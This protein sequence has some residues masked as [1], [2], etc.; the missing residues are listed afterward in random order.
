MAA[1]DQINSLCLHH[2]F[3]DE[4][5]FISLLAETASRDDLNTGISGFAAAILLERGRME[6]GE[7]SRQVRR[8]LS[9]GIPAELGAGWFAG[10]SKKNRYALIARLDLWR[11]LSAY[12]DTLDDQEFKRALVFLRRAFADFSSREKLDVAENL[13]EIWQVNTAQAGEILNGPLKGEEMELLDSLD[14]FDFDDI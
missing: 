2:D 4:A 13:G 7:L 9:R 14:G 10:L 5:R 12:M 11:E 1:M 8:R 3:L 6:E